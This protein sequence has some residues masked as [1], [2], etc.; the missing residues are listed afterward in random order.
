MASVL[1]DSDN[2]GQRVFR[3]AGPVIVLLF[4]AF[5]IY[6]FA[7]QETG[8]RV[9]RPS[10]STILPV[11]TPPPPPPPQ[12]KPPEVQHFEQVLPR[13]NNTPPPP[14]PQNNAVTENAEAQE[15]TDS[16]NIGAGN[17]SGMKGSGPAGFAGDAGTYGQYARGKILAA[18]E[19]SELLH[20]KPFV[21]VVRIWFGADGTITRVVIAR[22]TGT[23]AFDDEIQRILKGLSGFTPPAPEILSQMPIQFTIDERR[24]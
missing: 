5:A 4:V 24:S 18:V 7:A 1:E 23:D 15:G 20:N 3:Y 2:F 14:A 8:I 22:P 9:E 10:I 12:V 16:F 17:G 21:A 19:A 13:P 6:W 11:E